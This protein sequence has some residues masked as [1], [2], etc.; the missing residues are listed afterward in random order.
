MLKSHVILKDFMFRKKRRPAYSLTLTVP[1]GEGR[2]TQ[3]EFRMNIEKNSGN[4]VPSTGEHLS[5]ILCPECEPEIYRDVKKYLTDEQTLDCLVTDVRHTIFTRPYAKAHTF[6]L[7]DYEGDHNL[8][9]IFAVPTKSI[10]ERECPM[11]R[12]SSN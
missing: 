8:A 2:E 7:S 1:L 4:R 11:Q 3:F 10:N 6:D 9:H 5:L 12:M